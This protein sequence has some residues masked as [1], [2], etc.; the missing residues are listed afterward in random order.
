MIQT[1]VEEWF[2]RRPLMGN[3]AYKD[4]LISI[5]LFTFA[6]DFRFFSFDTYARGAFY[7]LMGA[8]N[9]TLP[10]MLFNCLEYSWGLH[11]AHNLM[12]DFFYS[13]GTSL[14]SW[15]SSSN[16]GFY[17]RQVVTTITYL[18]AVFAA[19]FWQKIP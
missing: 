9:L 2:F 6:H 5:L 16:M 13:P 10:V 15:A 1:F 14:F 3:N 19:A 17:L 18:C 8:I 12:V 11:L 7:Y 4:H